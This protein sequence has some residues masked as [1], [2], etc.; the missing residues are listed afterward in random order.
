MHA[1]FQL[2][3][4]P[5]RFSEFLMFYYPPLDNGGCDHECDN[6]EGSYR[7]RCRSGYQLEDGYY[8]QGNCNHFRNHFR[9]HSFNY[10]LIK[11]ETTQPIIV[12]T[13]D[14]DIDECE[15]MDCGGGVCLN[16]RGSYRCQCYESFRYQS[17]AC[18]CK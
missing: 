2:I 18:R 8:C 14:T 4:S 13:I 16:T 15:T 10:K 9:N 12:I 17:G 6:I 7:C 5:S 1:N 3:P 11:L